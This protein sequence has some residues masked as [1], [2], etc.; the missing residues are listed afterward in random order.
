MYFVSDIPNDVTELD[1]YTSPIFLVHCFANLYYGDRYQF[2]AYAIREGV[3]DVVNDND[4]DNGD[5][6]KT[7]T[8]TSISKP[9]TA[10]YGQ[11]LSS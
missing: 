3:D 7:S 2:S 6:R 9:F 8:S 4:G 10:I 5:D 1:N 11:L